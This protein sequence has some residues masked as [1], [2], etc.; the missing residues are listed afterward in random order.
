MVKPERAGHIVPHCYYARNY[1]RG[2]SLK[3]SGKLCLWMFAE[4]QCLLIKVIRV[5]LF[6]CNQSA[7]FLIGALSFPFG[8]IFL[9]FLDCFIYYEYS[10]HLLHATILG[11]FIRYLNLSIYLSSCSTTI[12]VLK[13]CR[14][15]PSNSN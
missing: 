15:V 12:T 10:E 13:G 8:N 7:S 14:I 11:L 2:L 6:F 5:C 9:R 3:H 1:C 4:G